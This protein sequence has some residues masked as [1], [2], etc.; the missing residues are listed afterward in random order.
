MR[1]LG[2]TDGYFSVLPI[3]GDGLDSR[4]VDIRKEK[5]ISKKSLT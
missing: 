3:D 2:T 1:H 4:S 5:I